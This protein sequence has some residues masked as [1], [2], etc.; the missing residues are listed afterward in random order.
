[1]VTLNLLV[2]ENYTADAVTTSGYDY[3]TT[4]DF[5]ILRGKTHNIHFLLGTGAPGSDADSAP[6]GSLYC[7]KTTGKWYTKGSSAWETIS[8]S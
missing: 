5:A 1:M 3:L 7:N 6:T 2:W 8:S 4:T